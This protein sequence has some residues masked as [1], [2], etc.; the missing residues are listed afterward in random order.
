MGEEIFLTDEGVSFFTISCS[1]TLQCPTG[2]ILQEIQQPFSLFSKKFTDTH[3][4]MS[5]TLPNSLGV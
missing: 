5:D 1:N 4:H 3:I 2:L